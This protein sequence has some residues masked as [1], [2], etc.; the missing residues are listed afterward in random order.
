MATQSRRPPCGTDV[1]RW[2]RHTD[3][4]NGKRRLGKDALDVWRSN[5]T[6]QNKTKKKPKVFLAN[7][8]PG[9]DM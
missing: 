2:Q 3:V 8:V 1:D 5:E 9:G 6:K 7:R 4:A